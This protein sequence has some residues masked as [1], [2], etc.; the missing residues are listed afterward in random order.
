MRLSN[1]RLDRKV[2]ASD[3]RLISWLTTYQLDSGYH[4]RRRI[5]AK[6]IN[7]D[8]CSTHGNTFTATNSLVA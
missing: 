5:L 7:D 4:H 6:V 2:S 1:P 3:G 8:P